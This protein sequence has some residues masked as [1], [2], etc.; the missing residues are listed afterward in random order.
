MYRT[1]SSRTLR[2][3]LLPISLLLA[4][5]LTLHAKRTEPPIVSPIRIGNL[6]YRA[7]NSLDRIGKV[8]CWNLVSDTHME[9]IQAYRV[10]VLPWDPPDAKWIC[11]TKLTANGDEILVHDELGRVHQVRCGEALRGGIGF[12]PK[13]LIVVVALFG[14]IGLISLVGKRRNLPASI[15]PLN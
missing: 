11:I 3:M 7:T 2:Y 4:A 6:E 14:V 9:T 13:L 15:G 12:V 5:S 8:E 10:L 1:N